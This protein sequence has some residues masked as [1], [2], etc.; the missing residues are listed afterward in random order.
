MLTCQAAGSISGARYA[1]SLQAVSSAEPLHHTLQ[2]VPCVSSC[3]SPA[4]SCPSL[5]VHLG[6]KRLKPLCVSAGCTKNLAVTAQL[7]SG[8]SFS[9]LHTPTSTAGVVSALARRTNSLFLTTKPARQSL[10]KWLL[11][12]E[13]AISTPEVFYSKGNPG[14]NWSWSSSGLPRPAILRVASEGKT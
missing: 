4:L 3:S 5:L 14:R 7:L 10:R 9:P 6:L 11:A 1:A 8:E 13:D 12:L 2:R